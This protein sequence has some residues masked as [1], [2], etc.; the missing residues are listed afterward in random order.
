MN[1][2]RARTYQTSPSPPGSRGIS[3]PIPAELRDFAWLEYLL[4]SHNDLS[5]PIPALGRLVRLRS[6]FLQN[7]GLSGPI[8]AGMDA[9]ANLEDLNLSANNLSGPIPAE[10]GGRSGVPLP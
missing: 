1:E 5:G 10:L 4:L 2:G 3:G 8:P 9:L 7:N 6:V